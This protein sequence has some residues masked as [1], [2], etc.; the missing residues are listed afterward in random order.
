MLIAVDER[1]IRDAG[2]MLDG[3]AAACKFY[4]HTV[5]R[6]YADTD[7]MPECEFAILWCSP[8]PKYQEAVK[9]IRQQN[10]PVLFVEYGWLP[11]WKT[12]HVDPRGSHGLASWAEDPLDVIPGAPVPVP[13]GDLL[14]TLQGGFYSTSPEFSPWFANLRAHM[15]HMVAHSQVP[16]RFRCRPLNGISKTMRDIVASR[17]DAVFDQSNSLREA[18]DGACALATLHSTCGVEAMEMGLPVLCYGRS[19]YRVPGAVWCMDDSPLK[20]WCRTAQLKAGHCDLDVNSQAAM[21]ARL[22]AKQWTLDD[23]PQR[24]EPLLSI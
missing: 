22:K 23:L 7:P 21:I 12:F 8:H 3:L 2:G 10:V 6:W 15:K 5:N 1:H 20:T 24:L 4:G 17:A 9:R 19:P 14:V 18:L 16:L 11:K 13:E